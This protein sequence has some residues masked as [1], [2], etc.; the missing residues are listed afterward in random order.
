MKKL[1]IS[2]LMLPS[3]SFAVD[4]VFEI[5]QLC[6]TT[7]GCFAGDAPGFPVTIN[8]TGSYRLTGNLDVSGL[9]DPEDVTAIVVSSF[10]TT[11]D[12]NGFGIIGPVSCAG[13]TVT[14]CT[15]SD[16]MGHGIQVTTTNINSVTTITNGSIRGMGLNGI[17]S[18]NNTV[19][20]N[21]RSINNGGIGIRTS[22]RS[23]LTNNHVL[24]NGAEGIVGGVIISRNIV[25]GNAATAITPVTD[26]KVF[27]N[28]IRFNGDD[29]IDC[30]SCSAIENIVTDNEGFGI[31]YSGRPVAGGNLIDTNDMGNINGFAPFE[32]APNRCGVAAC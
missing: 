26:A 24:R 9:I 10:N 31:T 30:N 6:A 7:T 3:I 29:G 12:L 23:N 1:I 2:L 18:E 22:Q 28:R 27:G 4:G 13:T 8:S 16:G 25:H 19:V 17:D 11:V 21:I 14:S 15:P 5:N 20:Q 32:I